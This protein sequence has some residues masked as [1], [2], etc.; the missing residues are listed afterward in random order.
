MKYVKSS[1]STQKGGFFLLNSSKSFQKSLPDILKFGD[2]GRVSSVLEK[3]EKE[4][5]GE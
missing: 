1:D 3:E 5:Q 4:E 2:K